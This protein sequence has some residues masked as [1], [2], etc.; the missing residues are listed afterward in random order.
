MEP[1]GVPLVRHVHRCHLSGGVYAGVRTTRTDHRAR[2]IREAAE[3]GLEVALYGSEFRLILP[4]VKSGS[5]VVDDELEADIL[6][7]HGGKVEGRG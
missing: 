3:A 1:L 2:G 5:V 4:A 7:F 6:G